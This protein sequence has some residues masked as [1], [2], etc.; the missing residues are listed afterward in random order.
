[1]E[2]VG[3]RI[4]CEHLT[5][6]EWL[7]LGQLEVEHPAWIAPND[8]QWLLVRDILSLVEIRRGYRVDYMCSAVQLGSAQ[9]RIG[10]HGLAALQHHRRGEVYRFGTPMSAE[11]REE[12]L[13]VEF[14][15]ED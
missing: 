15:E 6:D 3:G 5:P 9:I 11:V 12:I 1:M 13:R 8:L 7:L 14:G 10:E 2:N 4:N